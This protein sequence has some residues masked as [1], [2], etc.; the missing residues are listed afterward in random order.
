MLCEMCGRNYGRLKR[1][2]IEGTVMN[3]C[4]DC[5]KFGSAVA[6]VP[7]PKTAQEVVQQRLDQREKRFTPR[8]IYDEMPEDLA[9]DYPERIRKARSKMGLSQEELGLQINER[10]SII[11]KLESSH[12]RPDNKLIQKLEKALSVSLMEKV[13]AGTPAAPKKERRGLTLGDMIKVEE[14]KGKK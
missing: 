14:P 6:V 1:T 9:E 5:G 12:I 7:K 4:A 3:V 11:T 2:E 8:N 10:K 13:E